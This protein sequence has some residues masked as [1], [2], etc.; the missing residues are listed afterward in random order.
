MSANR[1]QHIVPAILV[2]LLAGTVAWIS[3]TREPADAYLFPRLIA[4]AMLI[5]AT[6][7]FIRAAAGLAKVGGGVNAKELLAILPGLLVMVVFVFFAAKKLGFYVA[8]ITAFFVLYSLYDPSPHTKPMVWLKRVVI[9]LMFMA[10]IYGLFTL[11][12]KVQTP[13]G[14]FI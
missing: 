12:L 14:M 6:W 2:L 8:S 11:L 5:L 1:A 7:N 4:G 9:S 3:F 10:V 13:R